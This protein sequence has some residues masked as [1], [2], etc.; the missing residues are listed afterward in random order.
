MEDEKSGGDSGRLKLSGRKSSSAEQHFE[1]NL[2]GLNTDVI[3]QQIAQ[4]QNAMP[5]SVK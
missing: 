1:D 4:I 3:K 2:K 5:Q